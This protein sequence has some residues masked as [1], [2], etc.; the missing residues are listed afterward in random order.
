MD[1]GLVTQL[2]YFVLVD[3]FVVYDLVVYDLVAV[4]MDEGFTPTVF[5][6]FPDALGIVG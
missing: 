3:P 6:F 1:E 2:V 4:F 5:I